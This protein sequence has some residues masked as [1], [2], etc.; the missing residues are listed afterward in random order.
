MAHVH[1]SETVVNAT[2]AKLYYHKLYVKAKLLLDGV[3]CG[4]VEHAK[5]HSS[6]Q[7]NLV[8]VAVQVRLRVGVALR[9]HTPP[10]FK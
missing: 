4:D 9:L 5:P 2:P 1:G 7:Q 6:L 8:G 3:L 10:N